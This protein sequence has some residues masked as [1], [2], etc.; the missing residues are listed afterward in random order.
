QDDP[1]PGG[2]PRGTPGRATGRRRATGA[3]V[4][5]SLSGDRRPDAS[6]R[7]VLFALFLALLRVT[8]VCPVGSLPVAVAR[9][10]PRGGGRRRREPD[11]ALPRRGIFCRPASAAAGHVQGRGG[12]G[13]PPWRRPVES[14]RSLAEGMMSRHVGRTIAILLLWAISAG[15]ARPQAAPPKPPPSGPTTSPQMT[16]LI[17]QLLDLF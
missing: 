2:G 3:P 16:A 6:G 1:D 9:P 17:E 10:R 8:R 14:R 5:H 13:A 11:P 4:L 7:R 12:L 15:G